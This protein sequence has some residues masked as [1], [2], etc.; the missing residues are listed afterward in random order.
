MARNSMNF[1]V[2]AGLETK[3][4]KKG[5]NELKGQMA[6]LRTSFAS[7]AAGIGIGLG[8]K[9]LITSL[10]NTSIQLDTAINTL[11]NVS[12]ETQSV[13]TNVGDLNTRFSS[14][15][16]NM[17]FIKRISNEYGQDL[18]TLT[19]SFAHFKAASNSAGLSL[20][21]QQYIFEQLTRA[22]AFYH[23]SQDQMGNTMLAVTQMLSKGKVAAQ[24][25]KLQL[26]NALPGAVNIMAKA[27]GASTAELEDMI[28]NGEVISKDAVP[29]LARELENITRNGSFDSLQLSL[30]KF[31]NA[32]YDFTTKSGFGEFFKKGVDIATTALKYLSDNFNKFLSLLLSIGAVSV[33]NRLKIEG[34]NYIASLEAQ[35]VRLEA[36]VKRF[37]QR[38][39]SGTTTE[40]GDGFQIFSG[41]ADM[42]KRSLQNI[43]EH[44]TRLLEMYEL[45]KKLHNE[46]IF[47]DEEVKQ[48]QNAIV[49]TQKLNGTFVETGKSVKKVGGWIS[50]YLTGN[51]IKGIK[52]LGVAF[53]NFGKTAA[54]ALKS[55]AKSTFWTFI[56]QFVYE[57]ISQLINKFKEAEEYAKKLLEIEGSI[58]SN[59]KASIE[60]TKLQINKAAE[61]LRIIG[62]TN[63]AFEIRKKALSDLANITGKIEYEKIDIN[64][65]EKGSEAYVKLA[66]AVDLWSKSLEKKALIDIYTN[67]VAKA[68][69]EQEK[70]RE[71]QKGIKKKR[72][73]KFVQK[74]NAAGQ[75]VAQLDFVWEYPERY[76]QIYDEIDAY[77]KAIEKARA[78]IQTLGKEYEILMDE[79]SKFGKKDNDDND[80]DNDNDNEVVGIAKV[81]EDYL[82]TI[83]ELKN[84]LKEGAITQEDYDKSLDEFIKKT[85]EAAAATGQLSISDLMSKIDKGQ[86]LTTMEKWYQEIATKAT[87]SMMNAMFKEA[88]DLLKELNEQI[89]ND[90]IDMINNNSAIQEM[91]EKVKQYHEYLAM[92]PTANK[93]KRNSLFDYNKSKSDILGEKF[94][95]ASQRV[96]DI[97]SIID[98]L[99]ELQLE[100]QNVTAEIEQWSNEL[101]LAELNAKSFEDAMNL[102]KIREDIQAMSYDLGVGIYDSIANTIGSIDGIVNSFERMRETIEDMDSTGWEKFISIFS[103][104]ITMIDTGI[105]IYETFNALAKISNAL[106]AA[107][108]SEQA[109]LNGVRATGLALTTEENAAKIVSAPLD[110][111]AAA[112]KQAEVIANTE[113]LATLIPLV[114]QYKSMAVA[115]AVESAARLPFPENLAA[116]PLAGATAAAAMQLAKFE[117]GGIV[118][119]NSTHGDRNIARVNSGEMILNK[120]QQGTLWGLLN[121][122]GGIGG[123]V[124]FKIK[125]SDLIGVISNENSRR[126]G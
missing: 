121:G 120:T 7:L 44:N 63:E 99:K 64:N 24:E 19:N 2:K 28:E 1:N 61:Y 41:S 40:I 104:F 32:W 80:D 85:F 76:S 81:Y 88:E 42:D 49:E 67:E 113:L 45:K 21:E 117:K 78:K 101:K 25:L 65:L 115:K 108:A 95:L 48:I 4:F 36:A 92:I 39:K 83:K 5:V 13:S 26:G 11:K 82:K 93:Y 105:G 100:G 72:K 30:N 109:V 71:E 123:N 125:G 106:T 111:T 70:L 22:A 3:N 103:T 87:G 10:K 59:T 53:K 18:V 16:E 43:E 54:T 79:I 56:I 116:M 114:A 34:D 57:K 75:M 102:A 66:K 37:Q 15:G 112:A 31:K 52:A 14:F 58:E 119:G 20:K 38:F 9:E 12:Y 122:Q 118:G 73:L 74:P 27:L 89:D 110:A 50:T 23:M 126:R 84:K 68:V 62:D 47:T 35:L 91:E 8:F 29:K 6:S 60:D 51:P 98:K 55:V 96:S 17:E 90:M 94:D 107:E 86:T 97:Q 46:K 124:N 33:F 69:Y 77:D